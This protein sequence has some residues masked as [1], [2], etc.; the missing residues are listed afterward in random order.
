MANDFS[1]SDF[2]S[3]YSLNDA[4]GGTVDYSDDLS[5]SNDLTPVNT[6]SF[7]DTDYQEGDGCLSLN[8]SSN[9]YAYCND[10]NLGS[11]F[12]LK[13]GGSGD[14][15]FC[16]W[17]KGTTDI[18]SVALLNKGDDSSKMSFLLYLASSSKLYGYWGYNSGNSH[19]GIELISTAIVTG[20]WYH[21]GITY[22]DTTKAWYCKLVKYESDGTTVDTVYENN[23]S[24]TNNI[25]VEDA[26]FTVG[27]W[28][29]R[30]NSF[31]GLIDEVACA[32]TA[33]SESDIDAIRA[34]TYGSAGGT[35]TNLLDGK[36]V[37]KNST[38]NL[39][40]GKTN[41]VIKET[42]LLDGKCII[43]TGGSDTDI[44]D[45]K[46]IIQTTGTALLDGEVTID[47]LESGLLDGKIS[48]VESTV[49][50]LSGKLIIGSNIT[51]LFDGK[52]VL[53]NI[54]TNLL[55]GKT[56]VSS[57]YTDFL[58]SKITIK[59]VTTV[60]LNGKVTI[61]TIVTLVYDGKVIVKDSSTD[62]LDGKIILP[63]PDTDLL[64]GKA[65]IKDI[66]TE[67]LDGNLNISSS[68]TNILDGKVY[69]LGSG[70]GLSILDGRLGVKIFI[71]ES[72]MIGKL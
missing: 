48:L 11:G 32:A 13:S 16:L 42:D 8:N 70:E 54:S 46:T 9:E 58:D 59:D 35:D 49:N 23:D 31:G 65:V 28:Y 69:I 63:T 4:G 56:I 60:L 15:T 72:A 52:V 29:D 43:V 30:S 21:L 3:V 37:V 10:A 64:D 17:F 44:L 41:I 50:L 39:F 25:N 71:P 57:A 2:V 7:E 19:E 61:G 45:G 6:P 12:P 18:T 27:N 53:G 5:A 33:V 24:V 26:P 38:T 1:G 68:T 36:L 40:D 67:N 66:I 14:F 51:E 62:L 34:G 22:N 47:N 55:D 20:R